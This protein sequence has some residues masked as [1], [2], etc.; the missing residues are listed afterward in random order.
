MPSETDISKF[1]ECSCIL[2]GRIVLVSEMYDTSDTLNG[3]QLVKVILRDIEVWRGGSPENNSIIMAS[4]KRPG[5]GSG[6]Y[7]LLGGNTAILHSM[8]DTPIYTIYTICQ[9]M[10]DI[11]ELANMINKG[12]PGWI[13]KNDKFISPF[14]APFPGNYPGPKCS[15]TGRPVLRLSSNII[16]TVTR[17]IPSTALEARNPLGDGVF[18]LQIRNEGAAPE[19]VPLLISGDSFLWDQSVVCI[20]RGLSYIFQESVPENAQFYTLKQGEL[21]IGEINTLQLT[22]FHWPHMDD[23]IYFIFALGTLCASSFFDFSPCY[24]KKMIGIVNKYNSY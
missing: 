3:L 13:T 12:V 8:G 24:H 9:G 14:T 16:F 2:G 23:R 22:N 15:V 10:T 20:N 21:V 17:V 5:L 18:S 1:V 4:E 19:K 6:Q 11:R 7:A